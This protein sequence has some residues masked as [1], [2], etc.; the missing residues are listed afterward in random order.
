MGIIFLLFSSYWGRILRHISLN[1][2]PL[3]TWAWIGFAHQSRLFSIFIPSDYF[4]LCPTIKHLF[5][6]ITQRSKNKI[7]IYLVG[8]ILFLFDNQN[9]LI[10][11]F[12]Q[13]IYLYAI[14]KTYILPI[15][16]IF[17]KLKNFS[18]S[19]MEL[20]FSQLLCSR[21]NRWWSSN[22]LLN[23]RNEKWRT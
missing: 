21:S 2:I 20:N 4:F 18:L 13:K 17:Y 9:S 6:L 7:H 15:H 23:Q 11:K 22:Q 10:Y 14:D 3:F 16:Y 5:N 8:I 12:N 1:I 19:L